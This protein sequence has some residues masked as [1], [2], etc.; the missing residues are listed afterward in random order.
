MTG[1]KAQP[2]RLRETG[3]WRRYAAISRSMRFWSAQSTSV[4]SRRCRLRLGDFLVRMWLV[5]AFFR[6]RRP[7]PVRLNR[8]FAPLLDFILGIIGVPRGALNVG[9][10]DKTAAPARSQGGTDRGTKLEADTG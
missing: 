1:R 5:K 4:E 6:L 2:A 7:V 9:L 3:L 8:F 10:A